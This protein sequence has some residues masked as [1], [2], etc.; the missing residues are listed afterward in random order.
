MKFF[1]LSITVIILTSLVVFKAKSAKRNVA[2]DENP[3]ID[4]DTIKVKKHTTRVNTFLDLRA[5]AFAITAEQLDITL[6]VDETVVYGVIMDWEIGDGVV[7]LVAYKSGDASLY[8]SSGGG[9]IGGGQHSNVNIVAKQFV[10]KAQSLLVHTVKTTKTELP[11]RNGLNFHFL[12]N[13]GVFLGKENMDNI[14]NSS[15]RWI[16][17]FT[18]A[19]NLI[20]ELRNISEE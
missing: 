3:V 8:L 17:L 19:N 4:E 13:K 16:G 6:S 7:T 5:M 15:S 11:E 14:E 18:E 20:T 9:I 12:T 1:Y 10:G 2:T